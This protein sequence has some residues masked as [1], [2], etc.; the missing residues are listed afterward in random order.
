MKSS[1]GFHTMTLSRILFKDE[2]KQLLTAFSKY[3]SMT[4]EIQIYTDK[5]GNKIIKF[6]SEDRGIEWMIRYNIWLHEV[7]LLVDY[8]YVTINPKILG[9]IKDYI[10][11]ATI[12]DMDAAITNFNSISQ[13][14]SPILDNFDY[15]AITRID[16]CV[17][18]SLRE[19]AP[20]CTPELMID[21]IKRA[22]IPPSYKEWMKYDK[23]A[24]RMKSKPGSFYLMNNSIHINCYSKYMQLLDRSKKNIARGYPP[25]PQYILNAARDIIRFEVQCYYRKTYQLSRMAKK[26]GYKKANKYHILLSHEQCEEIINHYYSKT[27]GMGHWYSLQSAISLIKSHHFNKQKEERLI[28]ILQEVNQ[29]RSIAKA[30]A[31]YQGRD[32]EAFQRSLNDLTHMGINSVTIPKNWGIKRIWNLLD[33]YYNKASIEQWNSQKEEFLLDYRDYIKEVL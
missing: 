28:T 8:L 11:A 6:Y 17:N 3:S 29:C 25:I 2:T 30:K 9:G 7:D 24:H 15:Y 13:S 22:D 26:A 20:N 27:I 18:F 4:G 32:L 33:S 14:I 16:Y 5:Y 21:L 1:M 31:S 19:L 23:T 12:D 10:T